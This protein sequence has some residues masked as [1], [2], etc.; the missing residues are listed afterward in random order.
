MSDEQIEVFT[1]I[2]E[3]YGYTGTIQDVIAEIEHMEEDQTL[4]IE[5]RIMTKAEFDAMPEANI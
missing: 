3:D 5:K 2:A 4:K 1:I